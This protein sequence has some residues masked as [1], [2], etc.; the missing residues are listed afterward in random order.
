[1]LP[2]KS[3]TSGKNKQTNKHRQGKPSTSALLYLFVWNSSR[4]LY[5]LRA[6]LKEVFSLSK[7]HEYNLSIAGDFLKVT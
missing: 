3:I 6:P 2:L 5:G 7:F 4:A 1:M